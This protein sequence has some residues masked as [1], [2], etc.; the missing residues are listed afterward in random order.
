MW[1]SIGSR[2]TDMRKLLG[3]PT[4]ARGA[5]LMVLKSNLLNPFRSID[6][7]ALEPAVRVAVERRPAPKA[8]RTVRKERA[9]RLATSP[10]TV[11]PVGSAAH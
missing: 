2:V 9:G 10:L 7:G 1:A 3:D 11:Q 5:T 8:R 4:V 6:A